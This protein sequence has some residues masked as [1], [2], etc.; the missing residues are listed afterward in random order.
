M[1]KRLYRKT[2]TYNIPRIYYM[3]IPPNESFFENDPY[4]DKSSNE[5]PD[6]F[7]TDNKH[8]DNLTLELFMNKGMYNKY[9]QRTNP[10]KYEEN[11]TLFM[12]LKKYK[13]H[14]IELTNDLVENPDKQITN[15][16]NDIFQAYVKELIRYFE[17]KAIEIPSK[18]YN[19]EDMLFGDDAEPVSS[20]YWGKEK[21]IR[22]GYPMN[23]FSR[24]RKF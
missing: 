1:P 20:S 14:I 10:Q 8:I 16:V 12:K 21:V 15:D 17:M 6:T 5:Q 9:I 23:S 22:S 11:Q 18:K 3:D 2:P 24:S 19:D 4:D 7:T 13:N